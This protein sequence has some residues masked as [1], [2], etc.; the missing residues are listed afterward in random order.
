VPVPKSVFAYSTL[1]RPDTVCQID[2]KLPC[3]GRP[4]WQAEDAAID[5]AAYRAF[6]ASLYANP[7]FTGFHML[8][9]SATS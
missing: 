6:V 2:P 8:L 9:P 7:E 5:P 1:V 4:A 3:R